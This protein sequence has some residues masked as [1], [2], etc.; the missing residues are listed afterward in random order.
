MYIG[1]SGEIYSTTNQDCKIRNEIKRTRQ[2]KRE[3][4]TV[5]RRAG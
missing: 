2:V 5:I 1:D 3:K 4:T